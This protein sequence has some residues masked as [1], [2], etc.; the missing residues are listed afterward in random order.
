MHPHRRRRNTL[1]LDINPVPAR[2]TPQR[3]QLQQPI[4]INMLLLVILLAAPRGRDD[5]RGAVLL[6]HRRR[7]GRRRPPWN[8]PDD[9][10]EALERKGPLGP[11]AA[12]LARAVERAQPGVDGALVGFGTELVRREAGAAA[13][14]GAV[15]GAVF[16]VG[17]L[18]FVVMTGTTVCVQQVQGGTRLW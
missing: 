17:G 14:G 13:G 16:S 15:D 9:A 5:A 8:V 12:R 18:V 1:H 11:L 2:L 4:A 3:R 7:L 6:G 10:R